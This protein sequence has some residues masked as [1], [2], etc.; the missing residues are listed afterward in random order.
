MLVGVISD[1]HDNMPK[2]RAAVELLR[3][4]GVEHLIHAGDWVAP[5]AVKVLVEAGIPF[6]GVFGNNDGEK[7]G[8]GRMTADVHEAPHFFDLDGRR[9][10][11]A[12]DPTEVPDE[13]RGQAD[14]VIFGHTHLILVEKG[15][16]LVLNPGEC[17][18]W[19]EGRST[20]ALLELDTLEVTILEV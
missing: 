5:F 17:C 8:I 20:V 12:H 1:S 19:L 16:P 14:V 7:T 3:E 15:P 13:M 9:I 6:T 10:V 2:L 11:L 4:R 18:G